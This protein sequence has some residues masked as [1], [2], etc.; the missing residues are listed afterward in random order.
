MAR[1]TRSRVAG[2]T[3]GSRFMTRET[4]LME[5]CASRATSWMVG[6]LMAFSFERTQNQARPGGSRHWHSRND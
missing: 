6:F 3:L 5:T 4:V 2:R 1:S